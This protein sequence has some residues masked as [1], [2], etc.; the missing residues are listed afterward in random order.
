MKFIGRPTVGLALSGGS[1][2]GLAHIGVI[3]AFEEAGIP[4]DMIAGTSMG[5]LVGAFYA[6][7]RDGAELERIAN[8]IDRRQLLQLLDPG[9]NGGLMAGEKV[10]EFIDSFLRGATFEKCRV[11]FRVVTTDLRTGEPTIFDDGEL[12]PAIRAS[13]SLPLVF[14][15]VPYRDL[16]L[17][18]GGLSLPLPARVVRD[19]GA[20]I[21]I[22]VNVLSRLDPRA[23]VHPKGVSGI[24]SVANASID[25]M[26][27][28]LTKQDATLSDIVIAPE[29]SSFNSRDF[30]RARPL[31]E[32]G[33]VSAKEVLP[34]IKGAIT[35][36]TPPLRRLLTRLRSLH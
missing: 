1:A 36:K 7:G 9:F 2:K 22:S 18:D 29:V 3:K 32:L 24:F 19:M 34:R 28:N 23:V 16:L 25:I 5:A 31:I 10:Y 13:I 15:P 11:P 17:T 35:A 4:I 12:L 14:N 6:A 20:D 27:R 30:D 21:V 8:S 26:M 33:A